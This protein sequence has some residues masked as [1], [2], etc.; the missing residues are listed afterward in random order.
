MTLFLAVLSFILTPISNPLDWRFPSLTY[1]Y[2]DRQATLKGE[3][4]FTIYP[5]EETSRDFSK[6][7]TIQSYFDNSLRAEGSS[8]YLNYFELGFDG[9]FQVNRFWSIEDEVVFFNKKSRDFTLPY[10]DPL[11][12]YRRK[13]YILKG[14]AAIGMASFFDLRMEKAYSEFK[15]KDMLL[16][17]GR[18]NIRMGPGYSANFLFSGINQPL[19]F[20]YYLQGNYREKFKFVFFNAGMPD[21]VEAKRVAYQRV[22]I[23]PFKRVSF[24]FSDA[25]IY[26]RKDLFKYINPVDF[27]YLIQRHSKDN[28]DNLI[29]EGNVTVYFP[30]RSKIYFIFLDDD[31][32]ITP[33]DN[34]A[35]LYGYMLGLYTV[36]PLGIKK[37]D[38]RFEYSEV[39]P[40][41]Y[42]H[43][44]HTNTW[45]INFTPLGHWAGNDFKHVF[46]ELGYWRTPRELFTLNI[47]YLKHG[48]GDL[49]TPWED[50]S[51]PGNLNWPLPPVE[52]SLFT[53]IM[54]ERESD[55]LTLYSKLG[56]MYKEDHFTPILSIFARVNIPF[57]LR[58]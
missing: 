20:L 16:R 36:N 25:V 18:F 41:T 57:I 51:L 31:W 5:I 27:Y 29:A 53:Y 4:L 39:S 9:K 22:E 19:D 49:R 47:E 38:F 54:Y 6:G 13:L 30:A 21:T 33:G 32:I 44:S 34:Q 56:L 8:K 2:M 10:Y 40:W 1:R 43:F 35:S 58:F 42:A 14:E 52:K 11:N 55:L 46:M 15:L 37:M 12:D 45:G 7:L 17:V 23:N 48:M 50:S 26:T 28:D 24:G 3:S